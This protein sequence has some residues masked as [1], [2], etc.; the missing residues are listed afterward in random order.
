MNRFLSSSHSASVNE[1]QSTKWIKFDIFNK[2]CIIVQIKIG[3]K[4]SSK[5]NNGRLGRDGK[6]SIKATSK[7]WRKQRNVDLLKNYKEHIIFWDVSESS[8][9]F[10][11]RGFVSSPFCCCCILFH[12]CNNFC[13]ANIFFPCLLAQKRGPRSLFT[14]TRIWLEYWT[15]IFIS[16]FVLFLAM[17]SLRIPLSRAYRSGR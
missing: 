4:P 6:N 17:F 11:F 15:N 14:L 2:K 3:I 12:R 13:R 8:S 10:I 7:K 9:S 1:G 16:W 5:R